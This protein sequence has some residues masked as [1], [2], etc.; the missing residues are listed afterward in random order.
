MSSLSKREESVYMAKLCE[1]CE[2]YDGMFFFE[3]KII[4]I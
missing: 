3:R 1:Q 4:Q 2:R